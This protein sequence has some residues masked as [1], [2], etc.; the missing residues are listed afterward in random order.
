MPEPNRILKLEDA[1]DDA[2]RTMGGVVTLLTALYDAG[3]EIDDPQE[4]YLV[5]SKA[6]EGA[7]RDLLEARENVE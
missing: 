3:S 7:M 5:M 1:A 2:V 4:A 6:L